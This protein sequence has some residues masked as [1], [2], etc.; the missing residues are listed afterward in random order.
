MDITIVGFTHFSFFFIT[1]VNVKA[2]LEGNFLTGGDGEITSAFLFF[3]EIMDAIKRSDGAQEAFGRMLEH[4]A[5]NGVD[6]KQTPLTMG[7]F[8]RMDPKRET[9]IR[10]PLANEML[11]RKYREP[12]VVPEKV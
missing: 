8:L 7:Q 12:Y 3:L 2:V 9:F 11:T 5:A 10:N 1:G 6:L 4:L